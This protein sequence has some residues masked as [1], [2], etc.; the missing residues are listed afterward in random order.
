MKSNLFFLLFIFTSLNVYCQTGERF[1]Y[2]LGP[3]GNRYIV[4]LKS[5]KPISKDARGVLG[6]F[7]DEHWL[8]NNYVS[9]IEKSI[10]A[11]KLQ[12]LTNERVSITYSLTGRVLRILIYFSKN[13]IDI[14]SEYDLWALDSNLRNFNMDMSK[15]RIEYPENWVQG[16]EAFWVCS[17]PLKMKRK[18]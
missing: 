16:T 5:E 9:I 7:L 12:K 6:R 2:Q 14:L 1:N 11:D 4:S 18:Q 13:S 17:F 10:P 8:T 3:D 15:I